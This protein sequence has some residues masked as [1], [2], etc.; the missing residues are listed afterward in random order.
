MASR[1]ARTCNGAKA[2]AGRGRVESTPA[3]VARYGR[4]R[5]GGSGF[6]L[7][8][9]QRAM[10]Q[11][12]A[13]KLLDGDL[14]SA[15]LSGYYPPPREPDG[16]VDE[17]KPRL[18]TS[19]GSDSAPVVKAW[20]MDDLAAMHEDRTSRLLDV[21]GGDSVLQDLLRDLQLPDYCRYAGVAFTWLCMLGPDLEDFSHVLRA[22][23]KGRLVPGDMLLVMN[24]ATVRGGKDT[25]GAF[26][27]LVGS[28]DWRALLD[29][30]AKSI[31]MRRLPC[32]DP[33][34]A[35]KLDLYA[36]AARAPAPDGELPNPV[37]SFMAQRWLHEL[38]KEYERADVAD[39]LP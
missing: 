22:V 10:W 5:L 39:R 31:F 34:R 8:L 37:H 26:E 18:C 3:Y 11:G 16:A 7:A 15:T 30:G 36:L 9:A 14:Q 20:V 13:V 6:L 27:P 19:P 29:A 28:E 21:S 24:E 38:E 12:R 4:G 1:K 2:V 32:M 35:G 25:L 17:G 23:E 33:I